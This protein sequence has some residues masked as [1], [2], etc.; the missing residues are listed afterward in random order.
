MDEERSQSEIGGTIPKIREG[1]DVF[2]SDSVVM[3]WN[4]FNGGDTPSKAYMPMKSNDTKIE[5]LLSRQ[6]CYRR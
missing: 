2:Q 3:K 6:K 4:T 1:Q 5:T